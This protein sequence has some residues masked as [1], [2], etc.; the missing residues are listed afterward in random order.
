MDWEHFDGVLPNPMV[1][2]ISKGAKQAK[3]FKADVILGIGGG[4]S[5]D[6]AKAIAVEATH[7]GSSWDYLFLK[8]KPSTK[9]L[10]VVEGGTTSGSGSQATQVAVV[11]DAVS[12]FKGFI[13]DPRH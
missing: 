10:P 13:S 12:L 4:S 1:D 2:L 11:T 3:K 5:L 8:Q 9:T 7:E 6:A